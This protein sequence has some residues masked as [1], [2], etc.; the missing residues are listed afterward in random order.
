MHYIGTLLMIV[1]KNWFQMLPHTGSGLSFALLRTLVV[2]GARALALSLRV[3]VSIVAAL[4]LFGRAALA[5][6][7]GLVL[8]AGAGVLVV[9][10]SRALSLAVVSVCV[11]PEL[12]A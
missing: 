12:N 1:G 9:S 5:V 6:V 3:T 8:G 11:R 4:V 2:A 10:V 7:A